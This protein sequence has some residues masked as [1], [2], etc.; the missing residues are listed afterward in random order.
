MS[1]P[2]RPSRE[3]ILAYAVGKLSD[4][5]SQRVAEFVESDPECQ[6]MLATLD[7]GDDTLVGQLRQPPA[8]DPYAAESACNAAL[9]R[10]KG[11]AGCAAH[12]ATSLALGTLGEYRL[13]EKLGQGGM[14]TVYKA[15]HT[16]L[17]RVVALKLIAKQ[18]MN[19]P[20]ALA[21]FEREMKAVGRLDHP[22]IVHAVDARE[23]DGTPVLVMEFVD[24]MDLG[25]LV[26]RH[27]PIAVNDACELIRRTAVALEY[28]HQHGLVHRD[29]K[30]SNLMLTRSGEVKVLDLGLARLGGAERMGTGTSPDAPLP[31]QAGLGS[32]PVPVLSAPGE[33]M[34]TGTSP[35][36]PLPVQP[37]VGSEPVP[38]LSPPGQTGLTF[39][40]QA[41]GTAD[42]MAPEQ[43]SCPQTVDIRADIYS[44]GCTLFKLLTGRVPFDGTDC[45]GTLEK[46]AAHI[47]RPAPRIAELVDVPEALAALLDR[48]LAKSPDDRPVTPAAVAEA[49]APFCKGHDLTALLRRAEE[50]PLGGRIQRS[51]SATQPLPR[52]R[53]WKLIAAVIGLMLLSGGIGFALGVLI[54]VRHGNQQTAL[55][56]PDE[57][58]VDINQ[59]GSINVNTPTLPSTS[60]RPARTSSTPW[61]GPNNDR[62]GWSASPRPVPTA[63]T[64]AAKPDEEAIQGTWAVESYSSGL[65][66]LYLPSGKWLFEPGPFAS[67]SRTKEGFTALRK[68][69]RVVITA[70]T[71]TVC[72]KDVLKKSDRY[73]IGPD[74]S[75]KLIDIQ[76][77]N[78]NLLGIYRLERDHLTLCV[79]NQKRPTEFWAEFGSTRQLV[80]LKR[81]APIV[82]HPDVKAIQGQWYVTKVSAEKLTDDYRVIPND[83][84]DF[85]KAAAPDLPTLSTLLNR[86]TG[87]VFSEDSLLFQGGKQLLA[88]FPRANVE[89]ASRRRGKRGYAGG[90]YT[91]SP[92]DKPATIDII[93]GLP[94]FSRKGPDVGS[95]GFRGIYRL[96]GETLRIR[97]GVCD[98][99]ASPS[100]CSNN[101]DAELTANEF[102]LLFSRK[103]PQ[104]A[105]HLDFRLAPTK[106]QARSPLEFDPRQRAGDGLAWF[107]MRDGGVNQFLTTQGRGGKMYVLL[108]TKPDEVLLGGRLGPPEWTLTSVKVVKDKQ[109]RPAIA[110][111]LDE[112]GG[113]RLAKLTGEH[114]DRPMAIVVDDRVVAAPTIK[115]AISNKVE[116]S[117]LFEQ[118]EIDQLADALRSGME[119]PR[120]TKAA[121]TSP[122]PV[123]RL[124]EPK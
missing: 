91:I 44:L 24:G 26:R 14:G 55:R 103:P 96:D 119:K 86:I 64:D 33:R 95:L 28:A 100:S 53:R 111:E 110:L 82:T 59:D 88:G 114:I 109:G 74:A 29:I 7:G 115:S 46:L 27:G 48:M 75:P 2:A 21:R 19:D 51:Q 61:W 83:V 63:S 52:I 36:A 78:S 90:V 85:N 117:G 106:E 70:D 39:T 84:T 99:L 118:R 12:S 45:G 107:E 4:A 30:P 65:E 41:M 62:P 92:E 25:R 105:G 54:T 5:D 23:I 50:Q 93:H 47:D 32:E 42:Y 97:L 10:A 35:N 37:G 81:V 1:T 122:K 67:F 112:A 6:A 58:T 87:A 17:D 120:E 8:D 72:G 57:S 68:A 71:F 13:L 113:K 16:K 31:V 69:A 76:M 79:A 20:Q 60:P 9:A 66:D 124:I 43:V 123:E 104:T 3:E 98:N 116:I 73:Q 77:P 102:E 11:D 49:L 40:G 18:R 101:F 89:D 56:V 121:P 34:G 38:V 94:I 22:G 80:V 108:T 15:L